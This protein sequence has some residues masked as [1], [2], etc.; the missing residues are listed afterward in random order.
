MGA[1]NQTGRRTTMQI[2]RIMTRKVDRV[3]PETPISEAARK[4]RED[5][6]GALPVEQDDRL[7]GMLTDRDIV[8]RVLGN[9]A[10]AAKAKVRD[11][12]SDKVLYVFDDEEADDVAR[13]MSEAQ[14]R[15]MPVVNRDK[16]LVGIVSL[17]DLAG[18]IRADAAA[19]ALQGVSGKPGA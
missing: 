16:R 3:T 15:R 13:N 11:A 2:A 5:D 7:V 4:M 9:G 19:R 6:V 12:M 17:G 10:D 14:V 18:H 8:V 1:L